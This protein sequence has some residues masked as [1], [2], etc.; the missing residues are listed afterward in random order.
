[1]TECASFNAHS[2]QTVDAVGS[3]L[4]ILSSL[5]NAILL[6]AACCALQV[7]TELSRCSLD[8][9]HKSLSWKPMSVVVGYAW[10]GE[11]HH[12]CFQLQD[13]LPEAF[14][15]QKAPWDGPTT[16]LHNRAHQHPLLGHTGWAVR[17]CVCVHASIFICATGV[18]HRSKRCSVDLA[19]WTGS[20]LRDGDGSRGRV[21]GY[22]MMSTY[23]LTS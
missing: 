2:P 12:V 13:G 3:F 4:T 5:V 19:A 21:A 22:R 20:S 10:I 1:M 6:C 18:P 14:F 11:P 15:S 7:P 9:L 16:T 23:C 17:L 8:V